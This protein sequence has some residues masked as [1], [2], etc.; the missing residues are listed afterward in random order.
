VA[1]EV[2]E[3]TRDVAVDLGLLVF[4]NKFG[5]TT[6]DRLVK[7]ILADLSAAQKLVAPFSTAL[8][9]L[10]TQAQTDA[11]TLINDLNSPSSLATDI[12]HVAADLETLEGVFGDL[13][14]DSH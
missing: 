8:A 11:Q 3:I 5:G 14:H 12:R 9:G 2:V 4:L 13:S 10:V 1:R 6:S 7:D